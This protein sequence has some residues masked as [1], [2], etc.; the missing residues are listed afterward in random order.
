[1]NLEDIDIGFL[2]HAEKGSKDMKQTI[3]ESCE[4]T[5]RRKGPRT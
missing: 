2:K 1:M 3:V 5:K 4:M